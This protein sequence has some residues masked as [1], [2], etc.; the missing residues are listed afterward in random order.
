MRTSAGR[1]A[2]VLIA[3]FLPCLATAARAAEGF[4]N[5]PFE[6]ETLANGLKVVYAPI[7]TSPVVHVRVL[8]HVG[9]KDERP[10][11]QGFAHMFEHMMFRG[12]EHVP[13]QQHM[14]LVQIVGGYSNAY[15][16]FDQTV[17]VNTVPAGELDLPLWLEAD[18]MASFKVS[19]AIFATERMVV[20]EEWRLRMNQPYGTLREEIA[21]EMFT[22]SHYRWTP[23]GKMEDLAAASAKD[24]QEFFNRYYVPN[25]AVLV[26]AGNIDVKAVK[27]TVHKYYGWIPRGADIKRESPPEPE[28]TEARRKEFAWNVPLARVMIN[29][30]MPRWIDEDQDALG[31]MLTIL[32]D[33]RSSRISQALVTCKDPLCTQAGAMG[34]NLEDGGAMG[35][36]ATVLEGKAAADVEKVLREQIALICRE[37]VTAE[38]LAKAKVQARLQLVNR[39]QTADSSASELGDEMLF[40][41]DLSHVNTAQQRIEA[42]TA[43]DVLR[44]AKKYLVDTKANTIIVT[45]D[46][47]APPIAATN[48]VWPDS[49]KAS[50]QPEDAHPV[51]FPA[52]YPTAPPLSGKVPSAVFEKGVEKEIDGAQVIVMTDHRLPTVNWSL[53]FGGGSYSEPADKTG[54]GGIV[55]S[56]VRRGPKGTTYNE[57]NDRLESR[58]IALDVSDGGDFTRV[59]GNCLTEQLPFALQQMRAMVREPAMDAA[60]FDRLK[61][62]S[63]SG[64]RMALNSPTGVA[65]R[66]LNLA[67]YGDTFLGRYTTPATIG[68]ITL[69]DVKKYFANNGYGPGPRKPIFVIAGDVSVEDGQKLAK[70]ALADL[71]DRGHVLARQL[72]ISKPESRR[73][74]IIDRPESK[75]ANIRMGIAAYD[76]RS[77][78]KFAGSLASQILSA[79]I[80][81]RLGRYV[82]A[83]KG[84][85]YGVWGVFS[86]TRQAGTFEVST[87][88]RIESCVDAVEACFKVLDD[89][90]AA[91]VTAKELEEAKLRVAGSMVMGMQT[92]WQQAQRRIDGILNGYP[93]DYYDVYPQR[94]AKVTDADI[95]AVMKK[96]VDDG[97]MTIVVVGP[98]AALKDNLAKLGKVEVLPMPLSR[99]K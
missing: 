23:I 52:D 34:M 75:Q 16:S 74:I 18:R 67:I 82:R 88:T 85:A 78:D 6:T 11:R 24:L 37:P 81:S 73:I 9:S 53:T 72:S 12:S 1:I 50:T 80:D 17:Y 70:E 91:P 43:D 77:D 46:P 30:P 71:A 79:G 7:K 94:I 8:Y 95:Q 76:I 87:D 25:N 42:I 69:D 93:V 27:E 86:P 92:V 97:R 62:Q 60:E 55:A 83:E 45:P 26:V 28:Q 40:R 39:W 35:V 13:P 64:T 66:E 65:D 38:E 96:Y 5:I 32:G 41:G 61:A 84:Y 29:Y 15:T 31:V 56:M 2:L 33:G 59:S 47:K 54:L 36:S 10:D 99:T 20:S 4:S 57:F 22:K 44:V 90:K 68:A 49:S 3:A 89:M 58:G 48:P 51:K 19:P 63:L 21:R 14:K 98:A